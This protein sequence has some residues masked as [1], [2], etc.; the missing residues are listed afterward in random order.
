[1]PGGLIASH[2][3]I[4][5]SRQREPM[6]TILTLLLTLSVTPVT[7]LVDDNNKRAGAAEFSARVFAPWEPNPRPSKDRVY[8]AKHG[9]LSL[10]TQAGSFGKVFVLTGKSHMVELTAT[11]SQRK[12]MIDDRNKHDPQKRSR[13]EERKLPWEDELVEFLYLGNDRAGKLFVG[14]VSVERTS[15]RGIIYGFA[16]IYGQDGEDQIEAFIRTVRSVN[17]QR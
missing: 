1:L 13:F 4:D 16:D 15:S 5:R 9:W 6:N 2:D 10:E 12:R 7:V 17:Y 8:D 3:V 14:I 11:R